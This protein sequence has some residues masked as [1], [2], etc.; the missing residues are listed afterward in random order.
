MGSYAVPSGRS[1]PALIMLACTSPSA[2]FDSFFILARLSAESHASGSPKALVRMMSSS[3]RDCAAKSDASGTRMLRRRRRPAR[4]AGS[5]SS[6]DAGA[7]LS[8]M[9]T[10]GL[11]ATSSHGDMKEMLSNL[12]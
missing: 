10:C 5:R 1:A 3:A 6:G 8:P 9:L 4:K 11:K 7:S 2:S 12:P